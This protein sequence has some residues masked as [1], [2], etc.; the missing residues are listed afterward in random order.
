M[1]PWTFKWLAEV[2]NELVWRSFGKAKQL[3]G[4]LGKGEKPIKGAKSSLK[5]HSQALRF[6]G[7]LYKRHTINK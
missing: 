4:Y 3:A 5:Y 7:Q 1:N 6:R 2:S